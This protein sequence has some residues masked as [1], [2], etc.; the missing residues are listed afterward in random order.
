[1]IKNPPFF[2]A[3]AFGIH[4]FPNS[5]KEAFWF[6]PVVV[7]KVC[8]NSR[9]SWRWKKYFMSWWRRRGFIAEGRAEKPFAD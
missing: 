4:G 9:F 3:F 1:M 8:R 5:Y 2:L 7:Q 6:A